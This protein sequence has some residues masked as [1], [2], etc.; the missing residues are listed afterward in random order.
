MSDLVIAEH[1]NPSLKTATLNTIGARP[2]SAA[3]SHVLMPGIRC[4]GAR[5]GCGQIQ[6]VAQGIGGGRHASTPTS[7]PR[8]V[9]A[10]VV[11]PAYSHVLAPATSFGKNVVPRVAAKLDVAQIS[12]IVA[13]ESADTFVRPIYAGN[14]LATV[15]SRDA[16]KVITVRTTASSGRRGRQCHDRRGQRARRIGLIEARWARS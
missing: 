4:A 16:I 12:D 9:A 2:R 13:V 14:A 6:G 7:L 11:T 8:T 15:R 10:L 5:A 3:I 1:D